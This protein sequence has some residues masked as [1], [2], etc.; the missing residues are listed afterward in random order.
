VELLKHRRENGGVLGKQGGVGVAA[1]LGLLEGF[2]EEGDK[3]VE[4]RV[5][6]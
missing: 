4:V 6:G 1:K 5:L 3:S 2:R